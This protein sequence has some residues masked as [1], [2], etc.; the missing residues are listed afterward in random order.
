MVCDL[1][2]RSLGWVVWLAGARVLRLA[3]FRF[4]ELVVNCGTVPLY[5]ATE[6]VG[7]VRLG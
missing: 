2:L 1:G 7:V 4:G 3:G 5:R 6:A